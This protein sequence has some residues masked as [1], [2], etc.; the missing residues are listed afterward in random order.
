VL[1]LVALTNHRKRFENVGGVISAEAVEVKEGGVQ[2]AP[3]QE[4]SIR[5]P[6]ER[7]AI[8]PAV[9]RERLKVPELRATPYS[10]AGFGRHQTS[11]PKRRNQVRRPR[12]RGEMSEWF[13]SLSANSS[14]S[15]GSIA[16]NNPDLPQH[17][18]NQERPLFPA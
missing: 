15:V 8:V 13:P 1:G 7:R 11:P 9:T 12:K 5:I 14:L 17:G 6:A 16:G 18:F 3:Y 2:L 10:V 4:P